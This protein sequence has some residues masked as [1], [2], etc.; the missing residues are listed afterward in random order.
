[1][2]ADVLQNQVHFIVITS[3]DIL[4]AWP[5]DSII[6]KQFISLSPSVN[7]QIIVHPRIMKEVCS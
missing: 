6:T 3:L 1:V 7:L 5:H 4:Q 2:S